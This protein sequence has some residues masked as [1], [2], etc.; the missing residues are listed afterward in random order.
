MAANSHRHGDHLKHQI[1]TCHFILK[2]QSSSNTGILHEFM[3]K[4]AAAYSQIQ[5]RRQEEEEYDI[6]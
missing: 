5:G 2:A 3:Q 1:S 6:G 4:Y